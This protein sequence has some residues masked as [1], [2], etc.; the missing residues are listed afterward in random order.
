MFDLS[1]SIGAPTNLQ[2]IGMPEDGIDEAA[3]RIVLDAAGNV[4]RPE[5]DGI[6]SML[7]AAFRGGRP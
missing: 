3:R 2:A 5:F 6:R 1:V 4:R 7:I